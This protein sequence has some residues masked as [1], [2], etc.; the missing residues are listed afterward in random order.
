MCALARLVMK[1]WDDKWL[2]RL[3][4]LKVRIEEAIR[5]MDDSRTAQHRFRAGWRWSMGRI[6]FCKRWGM[7]DK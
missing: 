5:Y 7:E 1:V 4:N 2:D 3:D 6:K